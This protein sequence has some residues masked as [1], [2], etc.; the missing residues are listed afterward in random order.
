MPL[1]RA[2][3]QDNLKFN[4]NV[5]DKR[6]SMAEK[7]KLFKMLEIDVTYLSLYNKRK[8]KTTP[9]TL[10]WICVWFDISK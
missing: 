8:L 6:R 4:F 5:R 1:K 10:R 2:P 3:D 7:R 9:Y